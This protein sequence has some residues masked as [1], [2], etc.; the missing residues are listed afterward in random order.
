MTYG[1]YPHKMHLYQKP[2]VGNDFMRRLSVYN[3]R[4]TIAAVGG[5]DTASC[6]IAVRSRDEGQEFLDQFIGNRVAF[7]ADNPVEPI[8]EGF[9][10]R[11]TFNAGGVQ[12]SIS[13]DEM[14]NQVVVVYT[15]S[16]ASPATTQSAAASSSV[17]STYS[18]SLYGIKE[19][20]VDL[21]LMT[22]GT[23]AT[24]LRDTVLAQ[25]A[26]PKSSIVPGSGSGGMLHIEFLGFY[27][28][29]MWENYRDNATAV[30]PQ[31]GVLV[32]T[33][34][35]GLINGTTFFNNA[36]TSLTIANTNTIN[37]Q[38]AKGETAW[39]ILTKI[40]E[41]GNTTNY[42]VIGITP[43]D[44]QLGTRRFYYRVASTDIVYTAR[45]SDGLRIRNLYGQLVPPWTVRP[46]AGVRVS[47]MLIGWNGIGDNPAETYITKIDYD[48]NQ[49]TAIY[50]GDDDISIEGAFNYRR[51]NKSYGKRNGQQR[52]VA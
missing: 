3:Y 47:D 23:G 32:D 27:H 9:I 5:F 48:A 45:Q 31:L 41:M 24:V 30:A 13:L 38:V 35:A 49:Q 29:L 10:N 7:Y 39:D 43:T 6:D 33:I 52:R 17:K 28:T 2:A 18:Q 42:F 46:D 1:V 12:Y 15:T 22:G 44:F 51:F 16:A 26:L 14:A 8:W 19:E 50:S 4:H 37:Q 21:G 11:M 40:Q 25:K 34:I 20:K 36:D